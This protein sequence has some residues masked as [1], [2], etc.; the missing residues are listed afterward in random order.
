MMKQ[1]SRYIFFPVFPACVQQRCCSK[2]I[3]FYKRKRIDNRSVD[4]TFSC[5]MNNSVKVI[6]LKQAIN[7]PFVID[8]TLFKS[9]ISGV[10]YIPEVFKIT[11]VSKK[12]K[13]D[14]VIRRIPVYKPAH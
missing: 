2:H 14:D 13:V 9:I 1:F 7:K 5:K 10:L 11:G 12:I 6:F 4:M 8:I 3:C